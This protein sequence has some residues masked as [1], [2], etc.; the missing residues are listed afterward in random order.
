[1]NFVSPLELFG[2]ILQSKVKDDE[3]YKNLPES[4][5]S[6]FKGRS[7]P[8]ISF[9]DSRKVSKSVKDG[10]QIFHVLCEI[11]M[12]IET[13]SNPDIIRDISS[14]IDKCPDYANILALHLY[15]YWIRSFIKKT[16][17]SFLYCD[18][19]NLLV[20]LTM[21]NHEKWQALTYSAFVHF[22]AFLIDTVNLSPEDLN[23]ILTPLLQIVTF[24][25]IT[26]KSVE[27]L[28]KLIGSLLNPNQ[29]G[30]ELPKTAVVFL[31]FFVM[32]LRTF[33]NNEKIIDVL[34]RII[35]RLRWTIV[36]LDTQGLLF[37]SRSIPYLTRDEVAKE[38]ILTIPVA[39]ITYFE[40]SKSI[41]DMAKID[42]NK[43]ETQLEQKENKII[44]NEL[45]ETE[46][47]DYFSY[48]PPKIAEPC[49]LIDQDL[50]EKLGSI[51]KVVDNDFKEVFTKA[52]IEKSQEITDN[53]RFYYIMA[54][55]LRLLIELS[56]I[57][58]DISRIY[59]LPIFSHQVFD[60]PYA[61]YILKLSFILLLKQE[62][63]VALS[64]L[65]K[66]QRKPLFFSKFTSIIKMLP[67]EIIQQ[68]AT[69]LTSSLAYASYSYL[70]ESNTKIARCSCFSMINFLLEKFGETLFNNKQLSTCLFASVFE[71]SPR[72]FI[73]RCLHRYF[74]SFPEANNEVLIESLTNTFKMVFKHS[75]QSFYV[76][77]AITTLNFINSYP[78]KFFHILRLLFEYFE[79][80]NTKVHEDIFIEFIKFLINI[81]KLHQVTHSEC[82]ILLK[83]LENINEL[84]NT[85]VNV[86]NILLSLA[87]GKILT[88]FTPKFLI[89]Q[90]NV[91]PLILCNQ[92]DSNYLVSLISF[93][94]RNAS[95]AHLGK[96]DL[97]LI[98]ILK[99]LRDDP[100]SDEKVFQSCL[101]IF[102]EIAKY[103]SSGE[104]VKRFVSLLDTIDS[105]YISKYH[106]ILLH[107]ILDLLNLT[108][109]IPY[110]S[111]ND[112]SV[113]VTG[114]FDNFL[115]QKFS[116]CFWFLFNDLDNENNDLTCNV[117]KLGDVFSL[118]FHQKKF[119]LL[120]GDEKK[121]F[122]FNFSENRWHHVTFSI[123]SQ[124]NSS[125]WFMSVDGF[126][127]TNVET[128]SFSLKSD[129]RSLTF[130]ASNNFLLGSF[131]VFPYL[132]QNH[133]QEFIDVGARKRIK[134]LQPFVYVIPNTNNTYKPYL[135][136][137]RRDMTLN[138]TY[139]TLNRNPNISFVDTL[140]E[141]C[142]LVRYLLP[143]F[144]QIELKVYNRNETTN[145]GIT[146]LLFDVF[147]ELLKLSETAQTD[148]IDDNGF[149]MLSYILK[150]SFSGILNF[151]IYQKLF[152]LLKSLSNKRC[153][154]EL[155]D[156]ILLDFEIWINCAEI[157]QILQL[158]TKNIR[159]FLSISKILSFS[160]I[161]VAL[162]IYFYV[163]PI[164]KDLIKER[165]NDSFD[166]NESRQELISLEKVLVST[167]S[168]SD[169]EFTYLLSHIVTLKDQ[170]QRKELIKFVDYIISEKDFIISDASI[171]LLTCLF[172]FDSCFFEATKILNQCC[173]SI[174]NK[175]GS[176]IDDMVQLSL[177]M[178]TSI[179]E[180]DLTHIV[181]KQMSEEMQKFYLLYAFIAVNNG[182][183]NHF[184]QNNKLTK[185]VLDN[186]FWSF[187]FVLA[188][189]MNENEADFE[190]SL[191]LLVEQHQ[192]KWKSIY[193]MIEFVGKLFSSTRAKEIKLKFIENL[194]DNITSFER[195]DI[196]YE[197]CQYF[198]FFS[199]NQIDEN[200][201]NELNQSFNEND[202]NANKDTIE[203]RCFT[204]SAEINN[205]SVNTLKINGK[206]I[207]TRIQYII[208]KQ[209]KPV[210]HV[211]KDEDGKIEDEKVCELIVKMFHRFP[212][213]LHLNL[214]VL[215]GALM[216]P[217]KIEMPDLSELEDENDISFYNERAKEL[218]V[219][220]LDHSNEK[221]GQ[222]S[223]FLNDFGSDN[224][225]EYM[226][227]E[228]KMK[229]IHEVAHSSMQ[230]VNNRVNNGLVKLFSTVTQN[231]INNI[232]SKY[233]SSLQ[234]YEVIKASLKDETRTNQF[235]ELSK[236][237]FSQF[238]LEQIIQAQLYEQKIQILFN[239]IA[240]I[241]D[242]NTAIMQLSNFFIMSAI[243][244]MTKENHLFY[245][246]LYQDSI[247]L[248][249]YEMKIARRI[250]MKDIKFVRRNI[251][252]N[253]LLIFLNNN[254]SF[255][256]TFDKIATEVVYKE[257]QK[258]TVNTFNIDQIV[259]E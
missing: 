95:I 83:T 133:L 161:L 159:I 244:H 121:E 134:E 131:G 69:T 51:V 22:F 254:E 107:S 253:S 208:S 221:Q 72:E 170:Q 5:K 166:I 236:V 205:K 52:L 132:K 48:E 38:I 143:A 190:C 117:V 36:S 240:P 227:F 211:R 213:D 212:S 43:E 172:K 87:A 61:V 223:E 84:P 189:Y 73:F 66:I 29:K 96:F 46:K 40:T 241:E 94:P 147:I 146:S 6:C 246:Y 32:I 65:N 104:V 178:I 56:P 82:K 93:S 206:E 44:F 140:V 1:M 11:N 152:D 122:D 21:R 136:I 228:M 216:L 109:L 63:S 10:N 54:A 130:T 24:T 126:P 258:Y 252:L 100:K 148:F 139:E 123:K 188:L 207:D 31:N 138:A 141:R 89:L 110:S 115:G 16:S 50:K 3:Q 81:H 58:E 60:N 233:F 23:E 154:Q 180:S 196:Y 33:R 91:L 125:F 185:E 242:Y 108:R 99:E 64:I 86:R 232:Y 225:S 149:G 182:K 215:I 74:N 250:F 85:K 175:G 137:Y 162:R 249:C 113:D 76:K 168:M 37:F 19:L 28:D 230:I 259:E 68:T 156:N 248:I 257:V 179:N 105:Q 217:K 92:S 57:I 114:F 150:K 142:G 98:N 198:L 59:K 124:E 116:I 129:H 30:T 167:K 235:V 101:N 181:E 13:D 135:D 200:E 201:E 173:S 78:N 210:F 145:L 157:R 77:I 218:D 229:N 194:T 80:I 70:Y 177:R 102:M 111:I 204:F 255:V 9:G 41:V 88:D 45:E 20:K 222:S 164:E 151:E 247:L 53:I 219:E 118:N 55:F 203:R 197:I 202:L 187:P 26:D 234:Q 220:L 79:A 90:K 163:E 174:F 8:L 15:L 103:S 160:Y 165:K 209:I 128:N 35:G 119:S 112:S 12:N 171:Q 237:G 120:F 231:M 47:I 4:V 18:L 256:I 186:E 176:S 14:I 39:I 214:I 49:D 62:H 27:L 191:D 192:Q 67:E 25:G 169:S 34:Y 17:A 193:R 224:I 2:T 97:Y 243:C 158:I 251:N 245:F 199:G 144:E 184:I 42:Q 106:S 127:V 153:Q 155:V 71:S 226:K 75:Y 239:K 238:S 183:L 7:F 195:A